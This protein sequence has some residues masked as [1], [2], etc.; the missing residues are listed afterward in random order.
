MEMPVCVEVETVTQDTK[1]QALQTALEMKNRNTLAWTA[2]V[3]TLSRAAWLLPACLLPSGSHGTVPH[4]PWGFQKLICSPQ[5]RCSR[6]PS[7]RCHS[8]DTQFRWSGIFCSCHGS[9]GK[10]QGNAAGISCWHHFHHYPQRRQ[11]PPQDRDKQ[12]F[13]FSSTIRRSTKDPFLHGYMPTN[14]WP[15]KTATYLDPMVHQ[16]HI[17]PEP[18][19]NSQQKKGSGDEEMPFNCTASSRNMFSILSFIQN[20]FPTKH[21]LSRGIKEIMK[22]KGT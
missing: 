10:G 4:G 20:M 8:S 5:K 15:W 16:Q 1:I 18:W 2:T 21:K 14:F 7:A 11:H 3:S 19:L 9:T 17:C 12:A 22:E 13:Q 6:H